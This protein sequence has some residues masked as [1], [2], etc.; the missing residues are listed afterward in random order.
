MMTSAVSIHRIHLSVLVSGIW[1]KKVLGWLEVK[2][3]ASI[4][5]ARSSTSG[6]LNDNDNRFIDKLCEQI[7]YSICFYAL[8]YANFFCSLERPTSS[9]NGEPAQKQTLVLSQ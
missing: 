3:R 8:P 2:P 7:Q 1:C 6:M 9:K 4:A 5:I